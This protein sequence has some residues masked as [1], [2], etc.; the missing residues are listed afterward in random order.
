[1]FR[2]L[3]HAKKH[4]RH[5]LFGA[6]SLLRSPQMRTAKLGTDA[7]KRA[8]LSFQAAIWKKITPPPTPQ[9]SAAKLVYSWSNANSHILWEARLKVGEGKVES[10][11][12]TAAQL[13]HPNRSEAGCQAQ[14]KK[15]QPDPDD[16]SVVPLVS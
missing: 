1:M 11:R 4:T 8:C 12:T 15:L 13:T 6:D 10:W 7:G 14:M 3:I 9:Q 2:E 5:Q 16:D